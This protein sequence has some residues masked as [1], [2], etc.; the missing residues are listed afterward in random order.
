M[1]KPIAAGMLALLMVI[2]NVTFAGPVEVAKE[3]VSQGAKSL[4][5]A[6]RLRGKRKVNA[7]S[8]GLK[9]YADAYK[10]IKSRGLEN[11]VPDL[12]EEISRKIKDT[13][14]EPEIQK[15]R[16][17]IRAKAIAATESGK[18]DEAYEQFDRLR[19]LDPRDSSI[20]YALRVIGSHL[21]DQ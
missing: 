1:F 4:K 14:A 13:G 11:D 8:Q 9:S 15:L 18:Y 5:R 12:L 7:L 3:H 10:L 17:D 21:E 2:P 19:A 20:E 6:K 16:Q